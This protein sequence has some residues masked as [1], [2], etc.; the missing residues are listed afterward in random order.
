MIAFKIDDNR[1]GTYSLWIEEDH[2]KERIL[3]DVQED[4]LEGYCSGVF[5][6][7]AIGGFSQEM[8]NCLRSAFRKQFHYI[9]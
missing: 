6:A 7:S 5:A 3:N 9:P 8:E 1:N 4:Y 2:R